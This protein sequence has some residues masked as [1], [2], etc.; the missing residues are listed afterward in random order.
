MQ[1]EMDSLQRNHAWTIIP[2]PGDK[3]L[4]NCK[5]IFKKNDGVLRVEPSKYKVRLIARG[6]T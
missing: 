6:F 4:V 5:W 2:N 1:D 3:K